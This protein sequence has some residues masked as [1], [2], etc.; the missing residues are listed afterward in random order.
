MRAIY[1]VIVVACLGLAPSA[2]AQEGIT[3]WSDAKPGLKGAMPKCPASKG[4]KASSGSSEAQEAL[5]TGKRLAGDTTKRYEEAIPE[6]ERALQ[7]DPSLAEAHFILGTCFARLGDLKKAASHYEEFVRLAPNDPSAAEVR[8][9]LR[10]YYES[11]D[12][13]ACEPQPED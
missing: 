5:A 9:V 1:A 7:L 10:Q 12:K 6:L 4:Q 13:R 8:M 3:C 2:M 11:L